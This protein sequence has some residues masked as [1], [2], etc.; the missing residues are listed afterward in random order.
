MDD[1]YNRSIE[2][3]LTG[4]MIKNEKKNIK[5]YQL[6]HDIPGAINHAIILH[7][8]VISMDIRNTRFNMPQ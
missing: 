1:C 5:D 3:A 6:K 2:V 4:V 7:R 8:Y